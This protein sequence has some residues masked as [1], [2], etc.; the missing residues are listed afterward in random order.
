MA[1][2]SPEQAQQFLESYELDEGFPVGGSG[3]LISDASLA[4]QR[5]FRARSSIFHS[6]ITPT[7]NGLLRFG[8][9]GVVEG[10]FLGAEIFHLAGAS[11]LQGGMVGLRS[12]VPAAQPA[13]KGG[14]ENDD[15][16]ANTKRLRV[17][18]QRMERY[19]G[20]WPTAAEFGRCLHSLADA[21]TTEQ[22]PI[23]LDY[24][25]GLKLW[26]EARKAKR[27]QHARRRWLGCCV[28]IG[29]EVSDDVRQWRSRRWRVALYMTLFLIVAGAAVVAVLAGVE[30]I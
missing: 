20:D 24:Q 21:D 16:S 30:I 4:T 25:A 3:M 12:C 5:M 11:W 2:S 9:K 23:V 29:R 18:Y 17:A 27:G 19:P 8:L 7:V 15:E 22:D 6:L 1:S 28:H 13:D 10:I 26:L 14:D